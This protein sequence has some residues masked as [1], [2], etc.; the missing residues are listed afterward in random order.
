MKFF[1]IHKWPLILLLFLSVM[2]SSCEEI[3]N[4]VLGE[5]VD[6]LF[7][8]KP[9]LKAEL[10]DGKVGEPYSGLITA[11]IKNSPNEDSFD[12]GFTV[13]GS[14]P[15]GVQYT[16]FDRSIRFSG[17]PEESG[18]FRFTVTVETYDTRD[19]SED[20]TCLGDNTATEEYVIRIEP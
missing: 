6:C 9:E 1:G 15:D 20:G 11:W 4:E 8:H 17:K 3:A 16:I 12:Y 19:D 5:A 18:T 14:I 7:P 10:S 13:M 2:V